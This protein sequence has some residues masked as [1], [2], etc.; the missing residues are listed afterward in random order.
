M[1][2]IYTVKPLKEATEIAIKLHRFTVE[3]NGDISIC[4]I[5]REHW[6]A[7][8]IVKTNERITGGNIEYV[9]ALGLTIPVIFFTETV[10]APNAPKFII[11]LYKALSESCHDV[12]C[13]DCPLYLIDEP[14]GDIIGDMRNKWGF[15]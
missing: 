11:D 10:A 3:K 1:S 5:L 4:G 8:V 15:E 7:G 13:G 2:Y 6:P 12:S 9:G 14:C